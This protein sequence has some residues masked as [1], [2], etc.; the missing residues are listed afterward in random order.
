MRL[1]EIFEQLTYG[2]LSQL[3]LGGADIGGIDSG[4]YKAITAHV[5]LGL[6]TLHKRFNLK[7]GL[8]K[9]DLVPGR[10]VYPLG[11]EFAATN[12]GS[13]EPVRYIKDTASE[14]YTG[15][16]I[17][18]D[19]VL[20]DANLEMDLNNPMNG[21]SC[22][23]PKL[24]TLR[25]PLAVVNKGPDLPYQLITSGLTLV[26]RANHPT[27]VLDKYSDPEDIEVALPHA[28]LE[29]LL[30]FIASRVNNP[31]GMT[32]E[33]NAGN[34]YAAKFEKACVQLEMDGT[35]VDRVGQGSRSQKNGWV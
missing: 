22:F 30:L 19:S 25:V 4:N 32:G 18:I 1:S 10:T 29:A 2:E 12:T 31:V 14:P 21:Y 15:D 13:S 28:Y 33:F 26:Y 27:L 8:I 3:S 6:T 23:T 35:E 20:T 16:I 34:N 17:K 9:L 7:E 5:N 24:G 11:V